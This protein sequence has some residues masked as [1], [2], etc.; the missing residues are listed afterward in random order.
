MEVIPEKEDLSEKKKQE[1]DKA[2]D[3]LPVVAEKGTDSNVV[4]APANQSDNEMIDASLTEQSEESK[5]MEVATEEKSKK[6]ERDEGET[7]MKPAVA[8]AED[9]TSPPK[10]DEASKNGK[11]DKVDT[12]DLKAAA[13][14]DG[15]DTDKQQGSDNEAED[16]NDGSVDKKPEAKKP[17]DDEH[18]DDE[19]DDED[20]GDAK[21]TDEPKLALPP[22]PIKRARTAYF[23]FA[24]AKR[25]EI[26]A[27]V[28][29]L[30]AILA[31]VGV[32]Q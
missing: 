18:D 11:V 3:K 4:A 24:D 5:P 16:D 29:T 17:A 9:T 6:R 20:D 22:R 26:K 27:K 14:T 31:H 7:V 10:V 32:R 19:D 8:A 23:I 1:P 2:A 21:E 13:K 28:R 25:E 30:C 15:G 12:V